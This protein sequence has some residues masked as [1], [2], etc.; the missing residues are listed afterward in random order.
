M[1]FLFICT[2]LILFVLSYLYYLSIFQFETSGENLEYKIQGRSPFHNLL[3]QKQISEKLLPL[4]CRL[5]PFLLS[6]R[7]QILGPALYLRRNVE[8]VQ[9]E[10]KEA[11]L[12]MLRSLT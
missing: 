1:L 7:D 4:F 8:R 12:S 3:L 11:I 10:I 6:T 2:C 5:L 9:V